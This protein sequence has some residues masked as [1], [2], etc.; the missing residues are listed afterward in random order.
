MKDGSS[1][2]SVKTFSVSIYLMTIPR[3]VQD[4]L[5]GANFILFSSIVWLESGPYNTAQRKGSSRLSHRQCQAF[6]LGMRN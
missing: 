2:Q 3:T 1:C 4:L 6:D 5:R